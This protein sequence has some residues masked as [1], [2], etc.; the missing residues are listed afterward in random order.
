MIRVG[1]AR[2]VYPVCMARVNIY[3]PDDLARRAREAGLNVSGVAQEA[4]EQS[5]SDREL[6]SWLTEVAALPALAG[7]HLDTIADLDAIRAE[8]GDDF[9]PHFDTSDP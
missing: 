4:L 9:P 8:A 6:R 2:G 5:L 1:D 3:L 7:S